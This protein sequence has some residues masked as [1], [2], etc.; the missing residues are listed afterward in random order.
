MILMLLSLCAPCVAAPLEA[1]KEKGLSVVRVNVTNQAYDFFRPWSKKAPYSRHALGAMLSNRR[2]LVT[3]ELVANATY[4]EL[5][6]AESGEKVPATVEVV[7]YE[8]NL[9]LIKSSDDDFLKDLKPIELKS[10]SIGD[11]VSVWQLETT[12]ALLSMPAL[13]TTVE[14]ARYPVDDTALLT[15][16]LTAS[17]QY[18]ESSF[19]LPIVKDNHLIGLLMRYDNRTQNVDVIPTP[20][21]EHFLKDAAG[22]TYHGFPRAGLLFSAMRDPQ[23]RHYAGLDGAQKSK[24]VYVTQV[25][26]NSPADKAGLTAGDVVLAIDANAI[27]QDGNYTDPQYGKVSM[28]HLISTKTYDGQSL[29]FTIFHK[30]E[31]REVTIAVAHRAAD[32][33]TIEPYTIDKAPRYYVLGGLVLQ[34]LTRQFLKEWGDWQKK[35]PERFVYYDRFQSELFPDDGRKI[36]ILSQVLPS[37]GAIGY[38]ELNNLVITRIND[39]PLKNLSDVAAAVEKPVNGFHKIEF[40]DNPKTIYLDAKEVLDGNASLMKNYRLPAIKRLE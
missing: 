20:V 32:S 35:A 29:K 34:E 4:V 30:G 38:E 39:V 5:E 33:Y 19:T 27:D 18:R 28:I 6:K 21:I 36:I 15:Y 11:S 12:G 23:L 16:R 26:K 37:P 1:K 8:A 7:D 10:A 3:A 31:T 25:T 40:E 22:G 2:V 14:I 17:L 13:L 24:G 9:A